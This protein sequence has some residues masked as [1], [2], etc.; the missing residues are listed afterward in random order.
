M[1]SQLRASRA[2]RSFWQLDIAIIETCRNLQYL[3][4]GFLR[5]RVMFC[6]GRNAT[7][8]FAQRLRATARDFCYIFS[9]TQFVRSPRRTSCR[10]PQIIPKSRSSRMSLRSASGS[11]SSAFRCRS[12]TASSRPRKV[13]RWPS[14]S[15]FAGFDV[16]NRWCIHP[17]EGWD[18]NRDG[19]P[20]EHTLRRWR[21]FGRSG[22]KLIWGGEAAAVQPDGRANPNQ[23]LATE[24]NRR[25]LAALL[26]ELTDAHREAFGTLDD[27]LVGLQLTHSGR[28]CKPDDHH[29]M[30]PRIAYHH[31]LL[32][33]KFDIDPATTRSCGPTTSWSS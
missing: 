32:D 9:D 2:G 16:G 28:F 21:N 26:D 33:A 27:L 7:P 3:C 17:M 23:T 8:L 11:P 24:S 31:P 22:A 15:K 14:R 12:T 29:K 5:A 19:S 13:R 10:T 20:S 6:H 25:G 30:A 1:A 18:A 4:R